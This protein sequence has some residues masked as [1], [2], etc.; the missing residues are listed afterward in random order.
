VDVGESGVLMIKGPNVMLGYLNKEKETAEVLED[1]W[2]NTGDIA[3]IDE[4]GFLTIT[5]RLSRFSKIGGEMVPHVEVEE[6]YLQGLNTDEQV[7]AVTGV[8]DARKGEELVVLYLDKAGRVDKLHEIVSK[9]NLPNMWKPKRDNYIRI[10]LM[11][12]LGSGKLDIMR[13][14]K[15]AMT[16]KKD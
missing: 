7:V 14:K 13:L 10:D 9:S 11:P 5:D 6:V 12:G 2:Y 15:I 8:P 3:G 4:D 16:A 1:G